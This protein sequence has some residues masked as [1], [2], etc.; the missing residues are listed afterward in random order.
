MGPDAQKQKSYEEERR[1]QGIGQIE[2]FTT[3]FTKIGNRSGSMTDLLQI[4]T[5]RDGTTNPARFCSTMCHGLECTGSKKAVVG[6]VGAQSP[7]RPW[8]QRTR[9][10]CKKVQAPPQ[11]G[12]SSRSIQMV[13]TQGLEKQESKEL[14]PVKGKEQCIG[15]RQ[16]G[17][18]KEEQC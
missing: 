2:G 7:W 3:E 12:P 14:S 10:I 15:N 8:T 9:P 4:G 17:P 5:N 11:G 1:N 18:E 6:M 13:P 16:V